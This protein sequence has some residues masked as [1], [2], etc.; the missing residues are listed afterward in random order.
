MPPFRRTRQEVRE[1]APPIDAAEVERL[2]RWFRAANYLSVG[3]I[4]LLDNPLLERSLRGRG[5]QAAAARPLGHDAGAQPR[6]HPPQ[7]AHP[8]ARRQRDLPGRTRPRRPGRSGE[9]LAGGHLQR[10]LPGHRLRP[11][12]DAGAVPPV[13]VPR[14]HPQPR[15]TRDA[16][17]DPRGRRARLRALARVRRGDGQPRPGGGGRGGRRRVRDRAAGGVVARQQVRRPG[18]RRGGAADPAPQRLQDR[19]PDGPGPDRP[20]GAR[21]P[22]ARLRP[23]GADGRGRR[24]VGRAPAAGLGHGPCPRHHPRDPAGGPRRR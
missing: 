11:R 7:P 4:Y 20:R 17:L 15:G 13:L 16:G 21:E 8:R 12:R 6:L 3:Q 2:D 24:P 18:P 9:R 23:R 22:A 1:G 14:R 19:Q 5:H 10:G